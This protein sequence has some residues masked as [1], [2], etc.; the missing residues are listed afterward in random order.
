[1]TVKKIVVE[2]QVGHQTPT[3]KPHFGKGSK[4][5]A[6]ALHERGKKAA[7]TRK[8]RDLIRDHHGG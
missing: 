5:K 4:A 2:G 3:G 7:I 8:L 6:T 1:M